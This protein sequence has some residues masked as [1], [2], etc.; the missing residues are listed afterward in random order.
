MCIRDRADAAYQEGVKKP[1][2]CQTASVL[3]PY[4]YEEDNWVDD[5]ELGAMELYK[6]T[7]DNKYLAQALE[8]GRREPVT[9]WM[10]ADLSLIHIYPAGLYKGRR[11]HPHTNHLPNA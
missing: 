3:S 11:S 2:A 9:P 4:I 6:A 1:G 7:G 10:G 5:M 8:Y